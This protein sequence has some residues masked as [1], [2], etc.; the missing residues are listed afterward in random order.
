MSDFMPSITASEAPERMKESAILEASSI[1]TV[2]LALFFS[3]SDFHWALACSSMSAVLSLI[4]CMASCFSAYGR[5]DA[6][7]SS[8]ASDGLIL[9]SD[10]SL[11]MFRY[12]SSLLIGIEESSFICWSIELLCL[13]R[14]SSAI[15]R[16][17]EGSM[18]EVCI[19]ET[20][21][22]LHIPLATPSSKYAFAFSYAAT[23]PFCIS[24]A[25]VLSASFFLK[26]IRAT[27]PLA[28]SEDTRVINPSV[29][30]S[31]RFSTDPRTRSFLT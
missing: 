20:S 22:G 24:D 12:R 8:M 6:L 30:S 25:I 23:E 31:M 2:R 7:I 19:S 1:F 3:K 14:D 9:F 27:S 13:L 17:L 16:P 4:A 26:D 28:M 15:A 10:S 21:S 5:L 29:L 11:A 18:R